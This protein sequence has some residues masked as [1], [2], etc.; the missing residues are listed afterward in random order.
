MDAGRVMKVWYDSM[1]DVDLLQN[2]EVELHGDDAHE[3]EHE[4]CDGDCAPDWE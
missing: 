4:H 3:C 1:P 2:D